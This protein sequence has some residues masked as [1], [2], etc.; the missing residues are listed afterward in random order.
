MRFSANDPDGKSKVK[1]QKSKKVK[2]QRYLKKVK[3]KGRE[4]RKGGNAKVVL[5]AYPPF[6][7]F[8]ALNYARG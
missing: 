3:R 7:F 6:L 8:S 1:I 2:G 4:E 5:S